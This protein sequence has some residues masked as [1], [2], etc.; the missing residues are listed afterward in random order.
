MMQKLLW[1]YRLIS[2]LPRGGYR[3]MRALKPGEFRLDTEVGP[4]WCDLGESV[5]YPLLQHGT[6]RY[7]QVETDWLRRAVGSED[8]VFDVG[9]NIGFTAL[10]FRQAGARVIAFEPSP[11][12]FRLLARNL[13]GKG[14]A[15]R[16]A[17]AE[18]PGRLFF[19]E[20]DQL[21][22]SHLADSGIEVE[23]V[24]I[25]SLVERPTFIKID[26]EGHEAAVLRGARETLK[27]GPTI[28]F[29]AL[30]AAALA[31]SS[32]IISEANPAYRI[33]AVTPMN[34]V[35]EVARKAGG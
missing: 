12:A 31:E 17:V 29:E 7:C 6:Y 21:N 27:G 3:V 34:Y 33:R 30:D 4:M 32:A 22:L 19:E 26:V 15:R 11:K 1:L 25:D 5:C 9:A 35:A 23:A 24:T 2:K 18:R 14:D 28:F 13:E 8:L 20:C 16:L 10:L